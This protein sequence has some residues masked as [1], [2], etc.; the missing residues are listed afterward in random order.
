MNIFSVM[1]GR[2]QR[3]LGVY[4]YCGFSL[5]IL[6]SERKNRQ[7][8]Y[9]VSTCICVFAKMVHVGNDQEK[10]QSEINSHSNKNAV[11]KN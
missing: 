9:V 5:K 1:S 10:A 6:Y 8:K 2:S 11:R 3:I 4:Q 7:C